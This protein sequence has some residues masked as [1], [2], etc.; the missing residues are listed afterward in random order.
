MKNTHNPLGVTLAICCYNSK[1]RIGETL[2]HV[3]SQ[4]ADRIPWE[5]LIID[6][7]STDGTVEFV[8]TLYPDHISGR[9]R[10]VQELQQG[11]S[12]ARLAAIRESRFGIISFIDDDN[13]IPPSWINSVE[14][15]FYRH[16]EAGMIGGPSVPSFESAPPDWF[17]EIQAS[18][19]VGRIYP[20]GGDITDN[21]GTLLW[22]AGMNVRM[23]SIRQILD[24][25]FSFLQSGRNGSSL[26][27]GEDSELCFAIRAAGWRIRFEESLQITHFIPKCRLCE[28]Y[29]LRMNKGM[30]SAS[31][32][33]ELY[34]DELGKSPRHPVKSLYLISLFKDI[35]WLL[36]A[37]YNEYFQ[38][39]RSFLDRL[40]SVH[41]KARF[42]TRLILFP[43]IHQ[44]R[45][46]IRNSPWLKRSSF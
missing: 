36:I 5:V 13:W 39:K 20:E 27:A 30:G 25:G 16:P 37:F 38:S 12:F 3:A 23:A 6:N 26:G 43:K 8:K 21:H 10:F 28:S 18:Y 33:L 24:K 31:I 40:G 17:H 29:A 7:A 1:D 11:L 46:Q 22:G 41:A 9:L 32:F 42:T 2:A 34:L 14:E 19:A 44:I 35:K 4:E 15:L 45:T